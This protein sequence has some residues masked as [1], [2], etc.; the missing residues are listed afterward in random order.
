MSHAR[1]CGIHVRFQ[2]GRERFAFPNTNDGCRRSGRRRR[3]NHNVIQNPKNAHC[4][5]SLEHEF[6][7]EVVRAYKRC[8]WTVRLWGDTFQT[9]LL[10]VNATTQPNRKLS[11][12]RRE[13]LENTHDVKSRPSASRLV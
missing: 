2:L 6:T 9:V 10:L 1:R 3:P 13:C 4:A 12:N 8:R 5:N 11:E 7:V